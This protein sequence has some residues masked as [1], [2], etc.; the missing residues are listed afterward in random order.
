MTIK[1]GDTHFYTGSY[2]IFLDSTRAS[3]GPHRDLIGTLC[4]GLIR[5]YKLFVEGRDY[6]NM[7]IR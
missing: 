1:T 6:A 2:G 5:D 4:E 7:G 3:S